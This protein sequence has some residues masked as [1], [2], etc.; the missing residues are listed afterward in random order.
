[1]QDLH[2]WITVDND[3]FAL[4]ELLVLFVVLDKAAQGIDFFDFATTMAGAAFR[5]VAVDFHSIAARVGDMQAAW[6]VAFL[7]HD[8][9]LGPIAEDAFV[10]HWLL[11]D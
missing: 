2:R 6:T 1:M 5:V 10:I 8:T 3:V 9:G 4:V 11:W 7:A